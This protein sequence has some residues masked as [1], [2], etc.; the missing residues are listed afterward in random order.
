MLPAMD[1]ATLRRAGRALAHFSKSRNLFECHALP[2]YGLCLLGAGIAA[3]AV[4][5][6]RFDYAP[7]MLADVLQSAGV[8]L[9]F[10]YTVRWIGFVK[11]AD[12]LEQSALLPLAGVVFAFY[13]IVVASFNAPIAD[14]MLARMDREFLALDRARTVD[15]L[16]ASGRIKF[17]WAWIYNSLK[18]T[19]GILLAALILSGE[20]AR[21]WAVLTA[22]VA[23]AF[24]CIAFIALMPAYGN[25]P[26]P[27]EFVDVLNGARDGTV[28]TFDFSVVT[29]MVT[30]PSMHAADAVILA[31]AFGWLGRWAMPLVVLNA[32]MFVS[33][34]TV[35]GH[36]AVDLI[37]GGVIGAVMLA[38]S[39]RLHGEAGHAVRLPALSLPRFLSA[40]T[41]V[42]G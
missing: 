8:V 31:C 11:I 41:V 14:G 7:A 28:R 20:R 13:S 34:L 5:P 26:F 18:F 29:V 19:P 42:S 37:A 15:L 10:V 33:A 1:R 17:I 25:P 2:V 3:C 35:G 38:L 39:L 40:R 22:L 27:Y 32:L 9:A 4:A 6:G 23:T 21:A 30:F 36:Y 24:V 16:M 12:L